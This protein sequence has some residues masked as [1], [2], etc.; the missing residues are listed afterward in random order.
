MGD[1]D[2]SK[3]YLLIEQNLTEHRI[4]SCP[5]LITLRLPGVTETRDKA[6]SQKGQEPEDWAWG[7]TLPQPILSVTISGRSLPCNK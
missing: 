2:I 7:M 4:C 6:V 3:L 5:T 1:A